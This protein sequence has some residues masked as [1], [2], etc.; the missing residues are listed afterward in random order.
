L[1]GELTFTPA[2]GTDKW[3]PESANLEL[4]KLIKL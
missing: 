1:F 4:G 3:T 2:S